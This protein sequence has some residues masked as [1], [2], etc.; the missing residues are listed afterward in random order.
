MTTI[1]LGYEAPR[2]AAIVYDFMTDND[3]RCDHTDSTE[4]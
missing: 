4:L 2:E 1:C 3:D